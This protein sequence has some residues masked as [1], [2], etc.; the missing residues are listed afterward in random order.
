MAQTLEQR[1][2]AP[3]YE[4]LCVVGYVDGVQQ[5][6]RLEYRNRSVWKTRAAAERHAKQYTATHDRL[7][8]VSEC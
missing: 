4:V 6:A 8:Y 2:A 3:E 5:I 1:L 7:A